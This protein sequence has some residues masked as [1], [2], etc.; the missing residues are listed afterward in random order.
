MNG[1]LDFKAEDTIIKHVLFSDF[2]KFRVPRYQRPYAW[3]VDQVSEFWNDLISDEDSHFI[4]SLIF[5]KESSDKTGRFDV[6]DGQQRLLTITIFS[7]VLRDVANSIDQEKGSL[8]HKKDIT[9]EDYYGKEDVRILP[10]ESIKKFFNDTIQNKNNK[11]LEIVPGTKE[12]AEM[13]KAYSYLHTKVTDELSK[14]DVNESKLRYLDRLREKAAKLVV[15]EILIKS[16][17][18]AY[19]I[20]ET[21]NARGV[22]LSVADLLKNLIFKKIPAKEDRDLAKEIWQEITKNIQETGS[23]LKKFIRYFWLSKYAFVGEKKLFRAIKRGITNWNK[24]LQ[25]LWDSSQFYNKLLEGNEED[26]QDLKN[27]HKI[28]KSLFSI[29][30]MNVSQCYVLFLSILR[31]M[32]KLEM[33]PTKILQLIEKFTFQYSVVCKLPG[34]KVEKIYTKYALKLEEAV[35]NTNKKKRSREVQRVFMELRKHIKE[36]LPSSEVFKESFE[37]LSYKNSEKTRKL[38]KYILGEINDFNAKTKEHK[39]DFNNVNIEH[40]LPQKPDKAWK[41]TKKEIKEYVNKIGN[42]TLLDKRINSKVQNKVIKEKIK[43]LEDSELPITKILVKEL[44]DLKYKWRKKE[45]IGRQKRLADIAY[46]K[47]WNC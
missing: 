33:D 2:K 30:L 34:N 15:I 13:K 22:D 25:D 28:Y 42:L 5:N 4:G 27:G 7:A 43:F 26:F 24:L 18:E 21:T 35:S 17:E 44:S 41:L 3:T 10:G 38:I 19:E 29:R 31:N 36:E 40:I 8:Y 6:I 32:N 45:I 39:I 23:E 16:E 46:N 11:I 47:V 20:F 14:F 12:Q 37:N 1:K 9:Q